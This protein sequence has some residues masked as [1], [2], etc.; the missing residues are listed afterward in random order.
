MIYY[1]YLN[2]VV[3][4]AGLSD[5]AYDVIS[6]FVSALLKWGILV[7]P[8]LSICLFIYPSVMEL[9]LLSIFHNTH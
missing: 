6:I 9:F 1:V 2:G 8:C 3:W 7:S 4:I 5:F